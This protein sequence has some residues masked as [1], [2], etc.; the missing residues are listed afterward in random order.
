MLSGYFIGARFVWVNEVARVTI[1][2]NSL[3][4]V[5]WFEGRN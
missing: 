5:G 4:V 1:F 3:A 2:Y